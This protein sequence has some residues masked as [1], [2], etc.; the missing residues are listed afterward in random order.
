MPTE[1]FLSSF[2]LETPSVMKKRTMMQPQRHKA[3]K[4]DKMTKD[5]IISTLK[6][7]MGQI[8]LISGKVISKN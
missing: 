2:G 1:L 6:M 3:N 7:T 5:Y 4:L 8:N